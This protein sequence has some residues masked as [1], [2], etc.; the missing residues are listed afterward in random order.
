MMAA[1]GLGGVARE[2]EGLVRHRMGRLEEGEGP[3]GVRGHEMAKGM[4][5]SR[6]ERAW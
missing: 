1:N 6:I 2:D 3:T 5:G 4:S